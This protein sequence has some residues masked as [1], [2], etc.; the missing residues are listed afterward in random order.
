VKRGRPSRVP[1]EAASVKRTIEITPS[2]DALLRKL[3]TQNHQSPTTFLR[4]LVVTAIQDEAEG[5]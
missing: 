3:A 1:G 5:E 4:D 2:E